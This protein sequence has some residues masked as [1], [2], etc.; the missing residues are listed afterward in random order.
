MNYSI[1]DNKINFNDNSITVGTLSFIIFLR[2]KYFNDSD[3]LN[4]TQLLNE[5]YEKYPNSN[6]REIE[7]DCK[8]IKLVDKHL[9]TTGKIIREIYN[10]LCSKS[11]PT[12][13]QYLLEALNKVYQDIYSS[14]D[15]IDK[16]SL[17]NY[18]ERTFTPYL[19]HKLFYDSNLK[20]TKNSGLNEIISVKVEC[21]KGLKINPKNFDPILLEKIGK[22]NNSKVF[23]YFPDIFIQYHIQEY[24]MSNLIMEFKFNNN[25]NGS[26]NN[27]DKYI[28]LIKLLIYMQSFDSISSALF[29][30]TERPQINVDKQN[31][32]LISYSFN[33]SRN[34]RRLNSHNLSMY[35]MKK[36]I[37]ENSLNKKLKKWNTDS[38]LLIYRGKSPDIFEN[39]EEAS[40]KISLVET[41]YKKTITF[42]DALQD[43]LFILKEQINDEQFNS[44]KKFTHSINPLLNVSTRK[45]NDQLRV[46]WLK[47]KTILNENNIE[48]SDYEVPDNIETNHLFNK[49]CEKI[50]ENS[51]N[52]TEEQYRGFKEKLFVS[53]LN[54]LYSFVMLTDYVMNTYFKKA[55]ISIIDIVLGNKDSDTDKKTYRDVFK[56]IINQISMQYEN[57]NKDEQQFKQD[58]IRLVVVWFKEWEDINK[59]E[60]HTIFD[61][62]Y[63]VCS[64][65]NAREKIQSYMSSLLIIQFL[66]PTNSNIEYIIE[67]LLD[68]EEDKENFVKKLGRLVNPGI[69][70]ESYNKKKSSNEYTTLINNIDKIQENILKIKN[71]KY[72]NKN[73]A[74]A[75]DFDVSITYEGY[76]KL[77]QDILDAYKTYTN[78]FVYLLT[79]IFKD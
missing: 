2:N 55:N 25:S 71:K 27:P 62:Y 52:W 68:E 45:Y 57:E 30:T 66:S 38:L 7:D 73:N 17:A 43:I 5:F 18:Q 13:E 33:K 69:D 76:L 35:K 20:D 24:H 59:K 9:D 22:T 11:I 65:S 58:L 46:N 75:Y 51:S 70:L 32:N 40:L 21:E 50:R 53:K 36:I 47:V 77:I 41:F 49:I 26:S 42:F 48:L 4:L 67:A 23:T 12:E 14:G 31:R 63:K 79:K 78:N 1:A 6:L 74:N 61:L 72:V 39:T 60:S 37:K 64:V 15:S 16:E 28:D 8:K 3:K 54:R 34:A 44:F 10:D 56:E 29:L 19:A